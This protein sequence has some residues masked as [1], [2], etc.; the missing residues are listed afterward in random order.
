MIIFFL[1]N[2]D[3]IQKSTVC[4]KQAYKMLF[5]ISIGLCYPPFNDMTSVPKATGL[6][7]KMWKGKP[8]FPV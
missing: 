5:Q 7:V 1:L 2:Q 8:I 4:N 6:P 3:H